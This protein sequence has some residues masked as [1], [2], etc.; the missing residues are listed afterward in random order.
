[1]AAWVAC[2]ME[3]ITGDTVHAKKSKLSNRIFGVNPCPWHGGRQEQGF[4]NLMLKIECLR[5]NSL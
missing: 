4:Y 1:M 2:Y 5:I 3:P